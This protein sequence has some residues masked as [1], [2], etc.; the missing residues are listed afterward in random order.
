MFTEEDCRWLNLREIEPIDNFIW[1]AYSP[2]GALIFT[3]SKY[4]FKKSKVGE[5]P[6]FV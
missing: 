1:Y 6:V 5:S 4:V 2:L 3:S